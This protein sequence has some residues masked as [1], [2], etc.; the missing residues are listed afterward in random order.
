MTLYYIQGYRTLQDLLDA[1][2]L[3]RQQLIG[4][5]YYEEF[6]DRMDRSEVKEI[7]DKVISNLIIT[8][9]LYYMNRFVKAVIK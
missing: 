6:K 3:N 1:N 7:E 9:I 5:K 2:I 4:I 8:L